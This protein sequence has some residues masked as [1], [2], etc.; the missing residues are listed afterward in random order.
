MHIVAGAT[1]LMADVLTVVVD[2]VDIVVGGHDDSDGLG[3]ASIDVILHGR[4]HRNRLHDGYYCLQLRHQNRLHG[5]RMRSA[6]IISFSLWAPE[7]SFC[8]VGLAQHC[9]KDWEREPTGTVLLTLIEVQAQ[10]RA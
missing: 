8:I 7:R 4:P 1:H 9:L 6:I 5:R 3:R 10:S 2:F